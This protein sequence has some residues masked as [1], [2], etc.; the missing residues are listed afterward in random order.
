MHA[1]I[2][3]G[4]WAF[5][6]ATI[7]GQ[8]IVLVSRPKV[9]LRVYLVLQVIASFIGIACALLAS[10]LMYFHAFIVMGCLT[11]ALT[12]YVLFSLYEEYRLRGRRRWSG[13]ALFPAFS[14]LFLCL[15]LYF[16]HLPLPQLRSSPWMF[17][18]TSTHVIWTWMAW[19]LG[20]LPLYCFLN[21]AA[22]DRRLLLYTLG[23]TLHILVQAGLADYLITHHFAHAATAHTLSSY[24]YFVTLLVWFWAGANQ[25]DWAPA[26]PPVPPKEHRL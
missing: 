13:R 22:Q 12:L 5:W 24:A 17:T 4:Q 20:A 15:A 7:V 14:L 10:A 6:A 19:L 2:T 18:Y 9:Y 16:S 8:L 23:L 1:K 11:D 3:P 26:R 25:V 21:G